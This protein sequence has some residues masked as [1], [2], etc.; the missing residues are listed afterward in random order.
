MRRPACLL[1]MPRATSRRRYADRRSAPSILSL[2]RGPMAGPLGLRRFVPGN[3]CPL[4]MFPMLGVPRIGGAQLGALPHG[5][6]PPGSSRRAWRECGR[7]K[8]V[9][10]SGTRTCRGRCPTWS[11]P[12]ATSAAMLTSVGVSASQPAAARAPGVP[13]APLD[14]VAAK[15][16]VGPPD[17]PTGQQ[18][19]RTGSRPHSAPRWHGLVP[20]RPVQQL[21]P[22]ARRADPLPARP[23]GSAPQRL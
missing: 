10:S 6:S 4:A 2:G 21:N 18:V 5:R 15:P 1:V 16:S 22:P 12:W 7:C 13:D 11:Y 20:C 8:S 9:R 17:D 3:S 23:R 19:P 14:A